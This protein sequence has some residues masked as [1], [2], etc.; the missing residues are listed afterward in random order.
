MSK[1]LLLQH[2]GLLMVAGLEGLDLDYMY[3]F[4]IVLRAWL[5]NPEAP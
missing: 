3:F 4:K 1:S 5:V 2:R